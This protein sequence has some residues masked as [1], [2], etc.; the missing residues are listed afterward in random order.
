LL[1]QQARELG[2]HPFALQS[3][4]PFAG[5]SVSGLESGESLSAAL[6]SSFFS[7]C[8][9]LNCLL[10]ISWNDMSWKHFKLAGNL[11]VVHEAFLT[12][13][14]H[15]YASALIIVVLRSSISPSMAN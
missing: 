12:R 15:T 14:H 2:L 1:A 9:S 6:S 4:A 8:G 10:H 5:S 13:A 3:Q 11:E 7:S